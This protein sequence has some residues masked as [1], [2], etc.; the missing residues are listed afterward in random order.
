[1]SSETKLNQVQL[2]GLRS[3]GSG[4]PIQR[5]A[6]VSTPK[7]VFLQLFNNLLSL[8]FIRFAQGC[9]KLIYSQFVSVGSVPGSIKSLT[10][11][12]TYQVIEALERHREATSSR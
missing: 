5:K 9:G 3:I 4:K 10:N 2:N 7:Q 6:K 8:F 1:M 11:I 12:F